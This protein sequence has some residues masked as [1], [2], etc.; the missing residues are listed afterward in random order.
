MD[1][2]L[3]TRRTYESVAQT[4]KQTVN[5]LLSSPDIVRTTTFPE[6]IVHL[7][8]TYE[9]CTRAAKELEEAP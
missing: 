3:S 8:D 2:K 5:L 6:V 7:V 1:P 4:L 9:T